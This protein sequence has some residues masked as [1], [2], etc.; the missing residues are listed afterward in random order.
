M[1]VQTTATLRTTVPPRHCDA[2]GAMHSSRYY[3]YFEDAFL[4]WLDI[5]VGRSCQPGYAVLRDAGVDLVVASSGCD[6]HAPVRLGDALAIEVQ[7]VAAGRTSLTLRFAIERSRRIRAAT[8]HTT[9]VAISGERG[10][11]PLPDILTIWLDEVSV[12]GRESDT[13]S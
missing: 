5:H 12:P 6:H 8:G 10:A 7:P 3:E 13:D 11:V 9:Y 2:Q 1:T 4:H